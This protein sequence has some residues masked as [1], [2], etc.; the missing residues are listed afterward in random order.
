MISGVSSGIQMSMPRSDSRTEQA[1]TEENQQLISDTLSQFDPD[2][3]T[4]ADALTIVETLSEAGIQP[5][6]GLEAALSELGFDAKSI[7]DLAGVSQSE[8]SRPPPPP[9]QQSTEEISE[10]VDFVTTLLEE[11]LAESADESLTDEDRESIY[12]QINEKFGF[13]NDDSI[14][15]L[16]A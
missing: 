4:E 14:I 7:G 9:P 2:N 6:Q 5:G 15:N 10:L 8:G 16:K 1:L 12:A 3:L 13:D 11:K